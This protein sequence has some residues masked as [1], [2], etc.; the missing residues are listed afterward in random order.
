[1]RGVAL[2]APPVYDPPREEQRPRGLKLVRS[3]RVEAM[4][5]TGN[6][7]RVALV[8]PHLGP[9]GAQRVASVAANALSRDGVDVHVITMLETPPDAYSLDPQV[10]RHRRKPL[11]A[12]AQ[13]GPAVSVAA[14][15]KPAPENT[16]L[17]GGAITRFGP[18]RSVL[19]AA[20]F[21]LA[22]VRRCIWL[23]GTIRK[24][25]PDAVLSFLTQTNI[26][27]VIATRGLRVRTLLS[28]RNDPK[29]QMHR[30]RVT[31]LRKTV[32]PWA[33]VVTANSYGAVESLKEFVPAAQLAFL[34]NPLERS[35]GGE[36]VTYAGPTFVTVT[37]LVEQKAV[38]VLLKAAAEALPQLPG[39][40]LA[41]V[42]DGPLRDQ[43]QSLARDLG[44]GDR[45]EWRGHVDDPMPYLKAAEAFVLTSRFEGSPN[46]LLEAMAQ[47][48][49]SIVSDASPGPLELI[50][51]EAGLVVPVEDA[52]RTADAMVRLGRD[53]ELRAQLGAAALEKTRMHQLDA[54]MGVWRQLL[55]L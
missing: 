23:R 19:S 41:I 11:A 12:A 51:D 17:L 48:L 50:G 30:R 37:R 10:W 21:S 5:T 18:A 24:I 7:K 36:V 42:G 32:Y 2:L 27:T 26:M 20:G 44:I 15:V 34:P 22:L 33:D 28:E 3:Y 8:I 14:G 13:T 53:A 45:V 43:L 40:R 29:L 25:H 16:S 1:M 54:A 46:A 35:D 4:A 39:W 55:R 49:P 31:F 52:S 47:G 6:R 38:D 9:G